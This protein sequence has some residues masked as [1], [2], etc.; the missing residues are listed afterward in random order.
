MPTS[1]GSGEIDREKLAACGQGVVLEPGA[2]IFHPE[3]VEIGDGVY[4]GHY[5]ILKG[6]FENTLHIGAGSWIGQGAFLHAGGG[7]IIGK[8]VGIG[9]GVKIISSQHE[10]PADREAPVMDGALLFAQV[11]L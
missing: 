11:T 1:H 10:M 3:N 6:Y 8:R 4:V 9:P 5:A 7:L 2:L